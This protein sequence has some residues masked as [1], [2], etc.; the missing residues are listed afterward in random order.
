MN[1]WVE[2]NLANVTHNIVQ[3]RNLVGEQVEIMPIVKANAYGHGAVE[4]AK[5]VIM[6]GANRLG[7]ASLSEGIELRKAGIFGPILV[8]S[9]LD[10]KEVEKAIDNRLTL[11]ISSINDLKDLISLKQR[12]VTSQPV[13]IH[14]E[15]DTGMGRLGIQ[16]EEI[17][18]LINILQAK[19][20]FSN[21]E[22]EGI[23][24]HFAQANV[25]NKYKQF[26]KFQE[27]INHLSQVGI[28][29]PIKHISN[30]GAI[31][32]FKEMHLNLVRPGIIIYGLY[33]APDFPKIVNLRP[34]M[35]FKAKII[36]LR[37]IPKG[38]GISYGA[39][40][41][42]YKNTLIATL[43]VG[44]A[45]GYNRLLSNNVWVLIKGFR[46]PIVG[47]ITMD[48]CMVDVTDIPGVAKGDEVI[49][50]G[51]LPSVDEL[52]QICQTINY[53]IVC[54]ISQRVPRVYY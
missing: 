47:R 1:K 33:P 27:V 53:E 2:I 12:D 38:C 19:C 30:S 3:I 21:L 46:A 17:R 26:N 29:I 20:P 13:K 37:K 45:D 23:F 11:T 25:E 14:L 9:P 42:T 49:L 22:V 5:T 52:A 43:P 36:Q 48:F 40:Y 32:S 54:G 50:F 24:S 44:Y 8:L 10:I 31:I 15:I 6:A 18:E 35:T 28:N 16:C 41:V 7:V 34:V 51:E 4:V 39:T